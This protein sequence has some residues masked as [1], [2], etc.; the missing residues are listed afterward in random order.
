VGDSGSVSRTLYFQIALDGFN[1]HFAVQIP[2]LDP[3]L[4][5]GE[6]PK[7]EA[8]PDNNRKLGMNAGEIPGNNG[9]KSTNNSELSGIFLGE[10][11]KG[12][13]FYFHCVYMILSF[14]IL[15][16]Q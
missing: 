4:V 1:R 9:I 10:I 2:R 16:H 8:Q 5:I 6:F 3:E 7:I 12:K 11:A 15:V 14:A 13:K